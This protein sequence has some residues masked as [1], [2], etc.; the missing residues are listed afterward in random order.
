MALRR[1]DWPPSKHAPGIRCLVQKQKEKAQQKQIGELTSFRP[2]YDLA[3]GCTTMNKKDTP[4]VLV[5][6]AEFGARAPMS[7][8]PHLKLESKASRSKRPEHA[9]GCIPACVALIANRVLCAIQVFNFQ[10]SGKSRSPPLLPC[11]TT[12]LT[13][14]RTS[15]HGHHQRTDQAQLEQESLVPFLSWVKHQ[16]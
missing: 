3:G 15:R 16:G 6:F 4:A 14:H 12:C 8:Q 9:L 10:A 11:P 7:G 2:Q 1:V 5:V 13:H